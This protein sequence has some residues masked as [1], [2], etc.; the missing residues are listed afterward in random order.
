[1]STYKQQKMSDSP[2]K[3]PLR[4][5]RLF[6]FSMPAHLSKKTD[7]L[8]QCFNSEGGGQGD[9]CQQWRVYLQLQRHLKVS[10]L[11]E[12]KM[13]ISLP[14][15]PWSTHSIATYTIRNREKV[16]PSS[17]MEDNATA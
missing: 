3:T 8:L 2:G 7:T 6:I 9:L 1:M 17:G 15:E 10:F 16:K 14:R 5:H 4:R 13:S 12:V 11:T